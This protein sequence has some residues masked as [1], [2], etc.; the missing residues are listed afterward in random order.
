LKEIKDEDMDFLR[1]R[2]NRDGYLR[3]M[4]KEK[5]LAKKRK[6]ARHCDIQASEAQIDIIGKI[7]SALKTALVNNDG[8]KKRR[9]MEKTDYS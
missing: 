3:V 6:A 8:T 5:A 7:C 2:L 1:C 4:A 9:I